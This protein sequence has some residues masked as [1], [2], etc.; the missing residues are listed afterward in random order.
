MAH[1]RRRRHHRH[2]HQRH[3]QHQFLVFSTSIFLSHVMQG[4]TIKKAC[5][6][7][8]SPNWLLTAVAFAAAFVL[9]YDK[10]NYKPKETY[11][12]NMTF[13]EAIKYEYNAIYAI[14][15]FAVAVVVV[16]VVVV[17]LLI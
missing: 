11:L 14:G 8:Y 17:V 9:F 2:H 7:S 10:S 15:I 13:G 3:E 4:K 16:A 5:F 6:I 1:C 12:L